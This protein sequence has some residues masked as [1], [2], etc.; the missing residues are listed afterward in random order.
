MI[1]H[2]YYTHVANRIASLN[3]R[4]TKRREK[5]RLSAS[6]GANQHGTA[7]LLD[8]VPVKELH[9]S[10]PWGFAWGT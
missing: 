9:E 3:H 7:V 2:V 6:S 4:V 1:D 10:W 5:V 8:G